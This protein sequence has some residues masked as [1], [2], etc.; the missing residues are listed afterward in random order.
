MVEKINTFEK[1]AGGGEAEA[2]EES[3]Q[4]I[5]Q[6]KLGGR[7]GLWL[8]GK[9]LFYDLKKGLF[10][11]VQERFHKKYPDI[12]WDTISEEEFPK[13]YAQALAEQHKEFC[14]II[15]EKDE[16]EILERA[17]NLYQQNLDDE[18]FG[19]AYSIAKNFLDKE[20]IEV[21]AEELFKKN[22]KIMRESESEE[23]RIGAASDLFSVRFGVP[24]V[25]PSYEILEEAFEVILKSDW[26]NKNPK[27]LY[28]RIRQ[29]FKDTNQK[30]PKDKKI[31]QFVNPFARQKVEKLIAEGRKTDAVN[32]AND[33]E[34]I[35]FLSLETDSDL[36]EKL[37]EKI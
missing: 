30:L 11:P 27:A 4:K 17:K 8:I 37:T 5:R 21:A 1:E 36:F 22:L 25:K 18:Y 2:E 34:K 9:E 12:D 3:L 16:K 24:E 33:L 29:Y 31:F 15:S 20:R 23:E 6:L 10:E 32:H 35:G 14:K 28:L 26:G 19:Q 7:F 13:D